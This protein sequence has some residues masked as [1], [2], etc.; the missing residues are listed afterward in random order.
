MIRRRLYLQ[1]YAAIVASLVLAAILAGI[2][3]A[4]FDDR[5]DRPG[6]TVISLV[7]RTLALALPPAGAPRAEQD[8]ALQR[9]G[10]DLSI[11]LALFDAERGLIGFVGARPDAPPTDGTGWAH[12]RGGPGADIQLPDGRR[13]EARLIL[14]EGRRFFA[15]PLALACVALAI[16]LASY[17]L[18]RRLTG[19]LERL[20]ESVERMGGGDLATRAQVEGRDEIAGLATSFNDAAGKIESLVEAH[21]T[22][23][24]NASHELRTPLSRIRLGV[25]MFRSTGEEDRLANVETDIR[26]L[27]RL[28]DEILTLSRLDAAEA[29]MEPGID[30]LGLVAEEGAR[31]GV[32][33]EGQSVIVA[34][35]RD[36]LRRLVRNLVE[37]ALRHGAPPVEVRIGTEGDTVTLTVSDGGGG[38]DPA[39]RGRVF[40][41]FQRGAGKQNVEGYGLGLPLVRQIAEAH[42][43]QVGIVAGKSSAMVVT[44]PL[45]FPPGMIAPEP[46][47]AGR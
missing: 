35:N 22:L 18:V 34:G 29:P 31:M 13:I 8:A 1:I 47:N 9:I 23:L 24:A 28:I 32:D 16:A 10:A 2:A 30:L 3:F 33:V 4:V 39:E 17:P 6:R 45:L 41:R 5:D 25:E 14:P 27:D 20:R 15:L 43:G 26:Q 44:L 46:E 7:E 12:H 11:D 21:R 40:E 36:L 38:I 42:G 19:R 37:N